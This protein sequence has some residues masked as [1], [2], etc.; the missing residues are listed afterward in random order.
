VEQVAD[1]EPAEAL[2]DDLVVAVVGAPDLAH[3]RVGADRLEVG[4]LGVDDAGVALDG[5]A[6]DRL[7]GL[8]RLDQGDRAGAADGDG[9]D[10]AG[11]EDAVAQRAAAGTGRWAVRGAGSWFPLAPCG[12]A[13]AGAVA[14]RLTRV[15]LASVDGR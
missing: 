1:L 13:P 7:A 10:G 3:A 8:E 4:E 14:H 6:E 11:K 5:D 9:D 15:S 12:V 2:E